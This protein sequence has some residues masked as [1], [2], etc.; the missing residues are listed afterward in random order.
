MDYQKVY[1]LVAS[2]A[3][4][5]AGIVLLASGDTGFRAYATATA[6]ALGLGFWMLLARNTRKRPPARKDERS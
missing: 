2:L 3:L 6:G 4:L 5:V 1:Y